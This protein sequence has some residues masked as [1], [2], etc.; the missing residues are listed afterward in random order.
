MKLQETIAKK[1]KE[2]YELKKKCLELKIG[3]WSSVYFLHEW[4]WRTGYGVTS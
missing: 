2:I 3:V 1:E 4:L